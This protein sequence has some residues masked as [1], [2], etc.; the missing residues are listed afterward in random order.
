MELGFTFNANE[1]PEDERSFDLIPA[2]TRCWFEI[3]E[4]DVVPTKNNNGKIL[5]ATAE[6]KAGVYENRK[7]WIQINVENANEQA[8]LI[9]QQELA[10][11]CKAVGKPIVSDTNDLMFAPFEGT[12]GVQKDKTGQY[13]DRNIIKT[14]HAPGSA[15]V[16]RQATAAVQK[17]APAPAAAKKKPWETQAAA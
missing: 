3:I 14:Y 12:L 15:P 16:A 1:V 8:Q 2:G 10:R 9:G 7:V 4:A 13:P 5:K 6:I 17:A 11:L